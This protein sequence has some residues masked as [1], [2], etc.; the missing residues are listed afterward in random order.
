MQEVFQECVRKNLRRN[1]L[2][3]QI[4]SVG[5][6]GKYLT[7]VSASAGGETE[8]DRRRVVGISQS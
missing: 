7:P 6:L 4:N 3:L 8:F 1:F 2:L 5:L